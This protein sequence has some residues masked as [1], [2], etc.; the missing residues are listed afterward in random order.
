MRAVAGENTLYQQHLY[1]PKI[2]M[3]KINIKQKNS[4]SEI[5]ADSETGFSAHRVQLSLLQSLLQID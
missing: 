5:R 4:M 2:S 3:H 1:S